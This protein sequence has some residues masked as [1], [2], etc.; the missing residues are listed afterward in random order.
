MRRQ[1]KDKEE[2]NARIRGDQESLEIQLERMDDKYEQQQTDF[3]T[4]RQ[5]K[6]DQSTTI[7][8]TATLIRE[9]SNG[10]RIYN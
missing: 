7:D 10:I 6:E 3:D 9:L 1:L 4:L 8:E 5:V 2:E